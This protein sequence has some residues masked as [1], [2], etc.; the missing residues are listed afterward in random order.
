MHVRIDQI[1][2]EISAALRGQ[3]SSLSP[4]Q[5]SAAVND[6]CRRR[7]ARPTIPI[8]YEFVRADLRR[9]GISVERDA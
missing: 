9:A 6:R 5:V 4:D 3:G 8:V 7:V 2:A 1:A